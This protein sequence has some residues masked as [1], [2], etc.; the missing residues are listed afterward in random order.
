M[1]F[2]VYV[3]MKP[4]LTP[5]YVGKGRLYRAHKLSPSVRRKWHGHIIA[6]YGR[7]N[8]IVETQICAS[9][10]EAFLRE[11]LVIAALRANGVELCNLTDGGEGS[12]G[13]KPTQEHIEKI[14][15][16]AVGRMHS[17]EVRI[18]MSQGQVGRKHSPESVAKRIAKLKG[19]EISEETRAKMS[20]ARSGKPLSE[21]NKQSISKALKGRKHSKEHKAKV[22]AFRSAAIG[23]NKDSVY[24]F[25]LPDLAEKMLLD[26][27][28]K[29][30]P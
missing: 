3:H 16:K 5:F 10:K 1:T 17:E 2:C 7:K 14:R 6:K 4:D 30:R 29:G 15:A 11:K 22:S 28:S 8:I 9:E 23:I 20:E 26:G 21:K 27:W 24:R 19:R 12:A 25:V 13:Y 18:R